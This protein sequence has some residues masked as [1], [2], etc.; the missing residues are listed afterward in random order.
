MHDAK[1]ASSTTVQCHIG[2]LMKLQ[3][4]NIYQWV[5]DYLVRL[6]MVTI[7]KICSVMFNNNHNNIFH[8]H[9]VVEW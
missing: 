6:A 7:K 4:L 2:I 3:I 8:E 5:R 1:I 9:A